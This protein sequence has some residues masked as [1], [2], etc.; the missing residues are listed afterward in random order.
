MGIGREPGGGG[1][2]GGARRAGNSPHLLFWQKVLEQKED[3]EPVPAAPAERQPLLPRPGQDEQFHGRFRAGRRGS[4]RGKGGEPAGLGARPCAA[5]EAQ[6]YKGSDGDILHGGSGGFSP[7]GKGRP[8]PGRGGGRLGRSS[9]RLKTAGTWSGKGKKNPKPKQTAKV[10]VPF[11]EVFLGRV[12]RR[13]GTF[14]EE[15]ILR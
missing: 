1:G 12:E 15:F 5:E 7:A 11:V 9:R 6:A 2:G 13:I 10:S 8:A 14:C 4:L 3:L